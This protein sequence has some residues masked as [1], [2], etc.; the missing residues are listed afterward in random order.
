MNVR[1]LAAEFKAIEAA[2]KPA[3][4]SVSIE[5]VAASVQVHAHNNYSKGWD[6]I[7]ECYNTAEI[8]EELKS[9][10]VRSVS[11]ALKHFGQR[12]K[13]S[14]DVSLDHALEAASGQ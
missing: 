10:K 1:A 3:K 14:N 6:F 4:P 13:V 9:A 11:G 5:E 12:V 8:V 7:V 2:A